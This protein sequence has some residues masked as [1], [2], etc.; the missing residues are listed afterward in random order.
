MAEGSHLSPGVRA[1]A[2]VLFGGLQPILAVD[3]AVVQGSL[4][5]DSE[6]YRE[7][8]SAA[9]WALLTQA[10]VSEKPREASHDARSK[11]KEEVQAR[12]DPQCR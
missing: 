2:L 9:V 11:T 6:G 4:V 5:A 10:T 7:D 8:A 1:R 3:L 12:S